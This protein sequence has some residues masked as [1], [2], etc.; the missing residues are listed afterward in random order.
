MLQ[1][2]RL[3]VISRANL[4]V[5]VCIKDSA[6]SK[7]RT[8]YAL[9]DK[10]IKRNDHV[11]IV[12]SLKN[13]DYQREINQFLKNKLGD[14]I[15]TPLWINEQGGNLVFENKVIIM[16]NKVHAVEHSTSVLTDVNG[17]PQ[18]DG[19]EDS[20]WSSFEEQLNAFFAK[21]V[22][23]LNKPIETVETPVVS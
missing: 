22:D 3:E 12:A 1:L 2:I 7:K 21:I 15:I 5:L 16:A 18:I 10:S 9:K 23:A 8:W 14:K 13:P 6:A 11:S 20:S 4:P 17:T 19:F